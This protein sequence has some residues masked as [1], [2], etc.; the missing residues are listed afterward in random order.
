MAG[1][2]KQSAKRALTLLQH[3][4]NSKN[5]EGFV[6]ILA[7]QRE[8]DDLTVTDR[9]ST[10]MVLAQTPLVFRRLSRISR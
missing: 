6:L 9:A 2:Q 5:L 4:G 10:N 3:L 8:G 1:C 7:Y